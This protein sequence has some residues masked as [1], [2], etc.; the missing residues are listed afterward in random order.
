MWPAYSLVRSS[1][2]CK[3]LQASMAHKRFQHNQQ[4]ALMLVFAGF[5]MCP[6]V[7]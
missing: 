4:H 2:A 7:E 1:N 6:Y 3:D 5:L